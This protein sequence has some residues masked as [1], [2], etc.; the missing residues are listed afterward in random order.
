MSK[1]HEIRIIHDESRILVKPK[2]AAE[3]IDCGLTRIYEL[4]ANGELVSFKDGASRKI[5]MDSLRDY[6]DRKIAAQSQDARQPRG[7]E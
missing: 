3:I 6:V 5:T 2:R 1:T 7:A 4:M